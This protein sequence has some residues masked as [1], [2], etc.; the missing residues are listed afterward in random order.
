MDPHAMLLIGAGLVAGLLAGM[1]GV[2]GGIIFVPVL[3]FYYQATGMAAGFEPQIT[4]GTSLFCT[5]IAGF[6]SALGQYKRGSV[7]TR[8]ALAVGLVSAISIYLV[9]EFI[10]T[11][12]WYG[13]RTFQLV[14]SVTLLVV[15][16][17]ML[18]GGNRQAAIEAAIER[19]T[20]S[21]KSLTVTGLATG[22]LSAAVGVGGGVIL[23]PAYNEVMRLPLQTAFG[24]SS[25]TIVLTSL[26]GVASYTI[27]GLSVDIPMT[28]MG[29]V[30]VVHGLLLAVPA[31]ITA[32]LGVR[33]AH[34]LDVKV[35]RYIFAVLAI[36][37]AA[38]LI[39]NAFT[40]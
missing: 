28:T 23:V 14:F 38:R 16:A 20:I 12:P 26:A 17:R 8:L 25:A 29:Y 9:T 1:I 30:D 18:T 5:L 10:T 21:R 34:R 11:Q 35:L 22:S 7:E 37:V 19:P 15:V 31:A 13:A 24:T 40:G 2:G 32:R 36:F 33:L 39:W 3:F 4:L 6:S 27:T